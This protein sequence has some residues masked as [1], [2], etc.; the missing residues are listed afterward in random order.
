MTEVATIHAPAELLEKVVVGGDLSKLTSGERMVF[1]R[2]LCDS[3][4]L[5]PLSRPFEYLTLNGKLTL[6]A[7][8]DATDQLRELHQVS[9]ERLEREIAEGIY[10]V[11]ASA[12]NGKGRTDTSLGAVSIEGLKGEARA[13]AMMKAETKAKRRVTLSIC[14][15][16][17]LDETEVETL[18]GAMLGEPSDLHEQDRTRLLEQITT[19]ARYLGLMK[20]EM[21]SAWTQHVG[22]GV[23]EEHAPI[24]SLL[25]LA[26]ML[27]ERVALKQKHEPPT[28]EV[29]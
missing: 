13:N 26:S 28:Q 4:G 24:A 8:K 20:S 7:R 25:A 27:A 9:I 16:G 11:T 23:K 14:G 19:D 2:T 12:R 18:P 21:K 6:Y 15:L 1:Y 10:C 3:V 29:P 5:N 22:A 17:L